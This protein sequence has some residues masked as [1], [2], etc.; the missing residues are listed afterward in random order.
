MKEKQKKRSIFSGSVFQSVLAVVAALL[1]SALLLLFLGFNPLT[2]FRYLAT[3]SFGSL[4]AIGETL[5]KATPLMLCALSFAIAARCG[6]MN[7]GATGQLYMGAITSSLV[8][9]YLTGLPAAIHIPLMIIAGFAGGA[10]WGLLASFLHQKFGANELIVTFMLSYVAIY[11]LSYL[12]TGPLQDL[13]ATNASPQ[14]KLIA[15][16]AKLPA[17]V[18]GT[19]ITAGIFIALGC[20]VLFYFL[21]WRTRS[22]FEMRVVGYQA[23]VGQYAGMSVRRSRV[24]AMFMAG[25]FAGIAGAI[26]MMTTQSRLVQ[27]FMGEVGFNGIAVALLGGNAGIAVSSVLFGAM[28][29]GSNKMQ[30]LAGVPAATVNI[31]QG[32]VILFVVGKEMFRWRKRNSIPKAAKRKEEAA[33]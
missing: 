24:L 19:R 5:V 31:I 17:I 8:G 26:E 7:L 18:K 27:A 12:V 15:E 13:E 11:F 21:L 33:A 9:I 29:A 10:L 4:N 30:M 28:N 16:T 25:G 14:S 23:T 3:G 1:I 6:S 20:V 2:A 22:G 32:L